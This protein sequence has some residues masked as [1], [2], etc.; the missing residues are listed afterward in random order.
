MRN[1]KVFLAICIH[2]CVD[3][4]VIL[5]FL[6]RLVSN[7]CTYSMLCNYVSARKASFVLY[8]LPYDLLDHSRLKFFQKPMRINGPLTLVSHNIIDLD[9]LEQI[10]VACDAFKCAKALRA[11][12]LTGFFGFL[13]LS[14]LPFHSL[15]V[16][17]YS[18]HLTGQD[19]FFSCSFHLV[20]IM[21]KWNITMQNRD[22]VQVISLPKLINRSIC[23]FRALKALYK[24]YPMSPITSVFQVH[25]N[26]G[27]QP[28][29][30]TK[31][32]K[33]LK[34]I[35]VSLGL[36]PHFYTFHSFRRSSATFAYKSHMP[37]KQIKR[38]GTWSSEC[39]WR[40]I[41]AVSMYTFRSHYL[42]LLGDLKLMATYLFSNHNLIF[43]MYFILG[44]IGS[45]VVFY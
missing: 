33:C 5:S 6:E 30:D 44:K 36:N 15:T 29:T 43:R 21:I 4:K 13:R 9:M 34:A 20:N 19:L 39:V 11:I 35:N 18:C 37:I 10:S 22:I 32:R 14:N 28:F 38:H 25:G 17:D 27:W 41:Q 40:C 3:V 42:Q 2:M 12:F 24:F 1:F 8:D 26:S 45:Y 23:P 7:N 31:V 16:F